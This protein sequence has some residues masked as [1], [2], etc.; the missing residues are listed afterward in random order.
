MRTVQR[1]SAIGRLLDPKYPTNQAIILVSGL[2]FIAG[3]AYR[4]IA[5]DGLFPSLG[6]GFSASLSVFLA[7]A[8]TRELDPDHE[9]A[10]F[11]SATFALIASVFLGRA[12]LL[13]IFWILLASRIVNR[14]TGLAPTWLDSLGLVALGFWLSL[15]SPWWGGI[16]AVTFSLD[17]LLPRGKNQQFF[18][19]ALAAAGSLVSIGLSV[20]LA[21]EETGTLFV[22]GLAL[23]MAFMFVP[24][25]WSSRNTKASSD[26]PGIPLIARRI[27]TAQILALSTACIAAFLENEIG[28]ISF[29]PVWATVLGIL[30]FRIGWVFSR[31]KS[32]N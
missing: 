19:A 2:T 13:T 8:L 4:L 18:F 3:S 5:N 14:T 24:I 28:L 25:I 27:Q 23:G 26:Q 10:A 32:E 20:P 29:F 31:P 1:W 16:T 15:Q 17:A 11:V 21:P 22:G 7:W 12:E 6:W 30:L 9:Y